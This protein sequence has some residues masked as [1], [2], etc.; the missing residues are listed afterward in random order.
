MTNS[1]KTTEKRQRGR[2][3]AQP[4]RDAFAYTIADA[5]SL[6][7]PGRTKMYQLAKAGRL[8]LIKV[9]GRTLVGGDSLRSLLKPSE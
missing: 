8:T 2:A 9:D 3:R 6:G 7:G 4:S 5:Q 1:S